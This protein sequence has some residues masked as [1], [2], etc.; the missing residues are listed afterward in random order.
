MLTENTE[1]VKHYNK[2][3]DLSD[4]ITLLKYQKQ[5]LEIEVQ[6]LSEKLKEKKE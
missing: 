3:V 5:S 2:P 1:Q 6:F 4:T